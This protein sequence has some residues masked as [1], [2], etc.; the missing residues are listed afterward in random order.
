MAGYAGKIVRPPRGDEAMARTAMGHLAVLA[1]LPALWAED[2]PT[3]TPTREEPATAAS[4]YKALTAAYQKAQNDADEA[5][6]KA[7][8]EEERRKVR[9]GFQALRSE[10][11]DRFLALAEKHPEDKEALLALF[12]VLHPDTESGARQLD[13]AVRLILKDHITSDRLTEP[14]ILQMIEDSPA[15][16]KLLRGV[17]AKSPHHAM[18]AQAC[19][20]LA[21]ILKE[22][23]APRPPAARPPEQ[24]ATLT[25]QAEELF[26]RVV[27][28]YADVEEVAVKAKAELFEVR[29]LAVGK[30]APDI[31]GKDSDGREFQLSDYRGKVVV[32]DFWAEW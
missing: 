9:A 22:R 23:A 28:K 17:M 32:L 14:P 3:N 4:G 7:P 11:I 26:E 10:F 20:S 13:T 12:F 16:E 25:R 1:L 24:A 6:A 21:L 5:F 29:H 15:G 2:K 19:L 18:Q 27:T 31:K 30:T 8:S